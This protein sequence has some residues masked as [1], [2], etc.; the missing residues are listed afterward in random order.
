MRMPLS[1]QERVL[2]ELVHA[3]QGRSDTR[4]LD[5]QYHRRSSAPLVPHLLAVLQDL[6]VRGLVSA[7]TVDRGTGPG[8]TLTPAGALALAEGGDHSIG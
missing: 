3:S 7:V 2:L 6:E 8:W 5:F 1:D 4:S